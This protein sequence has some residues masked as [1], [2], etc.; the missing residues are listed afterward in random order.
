MLQVTIAADWFLSRAQFPYPRDRI[1]GRTFIL[2][3]GLNL[4]FQSVLSFLL[5]DDRRLFPFATQILIQVIAVCMLLF[6]TKVTGRYR[7]AAVI[8]FLLQKVFMGLVFA[9]SESLHSIYF[10]SMSTDVVMA[11]FILGLRLAI[12]LTVFQALA[13]LM[14]VQRNSPYAANL[15]FGMDFATYAGLL[16]FSI[17]LAQ[18]A[19]VLF[20]WL[21]HASLQDDYAKLQ[22]ERTRLF[23]SART[24]DLSRMLGELNHHVNNPLS[25]IHAQLYR[26]TLQ[27]RKRPLSPQERQLSGASA[28]AMQKIRFIVEHLRLLASPDSQESI[29]TISVRNL[30]LHILTHF[31]ENFRLKGISLQFVDQTMN[32]NFAWRRH[33]LFTI[34]VAVIQNAGEA[35]ERSAEKQVTMRIERY[36]QWLMLTITDTGPGIPDEQ[37]AQLFKPFHSTKQGSRHLGLS[38]LTAKAVL[39]DRGGTIACGDVAHGCSFHIGLPLGSTGV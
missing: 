7:V 34:L 36:P 14:M 38:L 20:S 11:S 13:T 2:V 1:R 18:F 17:L 39:E 21:Y 33:E 29:S 24:F 28:E 3:L 23:R 4:L 27:A 6:F 12:P 30:C 9:S 15:P 5:P 8:H 10:A 31:Q 19:M 26:L 22:R 32:M 16:A 37:R 25:V 35:V